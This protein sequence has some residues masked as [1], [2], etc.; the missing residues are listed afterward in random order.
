MTAPLSPAIHMGA[1]RLLVVGVRRWRSPDEM[2]PGGRPGRK[3]SLPPSEIAG[4]LLNAVFLESIEADV[5]RLENVNRMVELVPPAERAKLPHRVR[6]IPTLVLRPS[7][8]L[9]QLAGDQYRRFPRIL[10]YLFRGIGARGENGS[11]LLSYLAFE[12]IYVKRLMDLGYEDTMA[13]RREVET[14]FGER[15]IGRE[16]SRARA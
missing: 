8:D 2:T 15:R 4:T 7:R 10:R 5:E 16:G 14:F 9:A 12:P 6:S 13:R 1:E 11:D 3:D